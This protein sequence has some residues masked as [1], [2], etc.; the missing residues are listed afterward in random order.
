MNFKGLI[1]TPILIFSIAIAAS[2][3]TKKNPQESLTDTRLPAS[4]DSYESSHLN[5]EDSGLQ[6]QIET[7][8]KFLKHL[9]V[10]QKVRPPISII[11]D[12]KSAGRIGSNQEFELTA[13]VSSK[14]KADSIQVDWQLPAGVEVIGGEVSHVI[15]NLKANEKRVIRITLKSLSSENQQIH[16]IAKGN[17]RGESLTS[18]DQFNTADE[19]DIERAKAELVKR[20]SRYVDP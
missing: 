6:N 2:L 5:N 15:S 4:D 1:L 18:G 9:N 16:I 11:I 10:H 14:T 12:K 7:S 8:K 20:H 17:Y 19:E 13:E 3:A